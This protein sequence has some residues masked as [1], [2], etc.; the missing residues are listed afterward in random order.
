MDIKRAPGFPLS[1]SSRERAG[2]RVLRRLQNRAPVDQVLP[3]PHAVDARIPQGERGEHR[4]APMI[5]A[6]DTLL[7]GVLLGG[8]YALF[9]A[10]L[11]LIFGVM[12]LVNLAHGDM[13]VL[14]AFL[15]FAA[16][17][18]PRPQPAP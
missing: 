1:R 18:Q 5:P 3:T 9:A 6:L 8:L 12:R 4:V 16:D 14:A 17:A 15:M 2:A 7:Q 13:I 11:S 10:G